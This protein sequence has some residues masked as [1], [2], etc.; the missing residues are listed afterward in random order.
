MMYCR[1]RDS[2]LSLLSSLEVLAYNK[3]L[4]LNMPLQLHHTPIRTIW[5]F[6]GPNFLRLILLTQTPSTWLIHSKP[7]AVD[8]D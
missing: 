4:T 2:L 6:P 8:A 5:H 7:I 1:A 3:G